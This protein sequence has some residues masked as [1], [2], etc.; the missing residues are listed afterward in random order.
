[1]ALALAIG[2]LPASQ[3]A[4]IAECLAFPLGTD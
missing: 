2:A 4:A 1:M 3:T